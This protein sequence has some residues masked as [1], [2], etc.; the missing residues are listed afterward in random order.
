M[1]IGPRT[2][3]RDDPVDGNDPPQGQQQR[4]QVPPARTSDDQLAQQPDKSLRPTKRPFPRTS[5]PSEQPGVYQGPVREVC[6]L[7]RWA[8][9]NENQEGFDR[10]LGSIAR[11][12]LLPVILPVCLII[13]LVATVILLDSIP[14]VSLVVKIITSAATSTM[15]SVAAWLSS[16]KSKARRSKRRHQEIVSD[17][18]DDDRSGSSGDNG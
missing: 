8:A 16:R 4:A 3:N 9:E 7:I 2:G 6:N 11:R 13:S 14:H 18:S 17:D 10:A 15:I 12:I 1:T 5:G